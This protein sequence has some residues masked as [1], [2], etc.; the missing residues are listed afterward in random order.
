[1]DLRWAVPIPATKTC[2]QAPQNGNVDGKATAIIAAGQPD[3]S[4]LWLRLNAKPDDGWFMPQIAVSI[5]QPGVTEMLS[6]W[7]KSLKCP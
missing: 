4:A 3:K 5:A 6:A 2:N 1:M 7:I